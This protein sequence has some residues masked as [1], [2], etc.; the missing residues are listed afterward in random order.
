[1]RARSELV[2]EFLEALKKIEKQHPLQQSED[3]EIDLGNGVTMLLSLEEAAI[4]K[5]AF[6]LVKTAN[7]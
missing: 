4:V 3:I 1:M 7:E 5:P 6:F 2:T